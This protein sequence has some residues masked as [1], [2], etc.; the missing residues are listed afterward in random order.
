MTIPDRIAKAATNGAISPWAALLYGRM[1]QLANQEG[2]CIAPLSTLAAEMG[3]T[4]KG[5]RK[6]L[7]EL[8]AIGE[9]Q[10]T[11]TGWV[12][13]VEFS[14]TPGEA[15]QT[16]P[17]PQ[18]QTQPQAQTAPASPPQPPQPPQPETDAAPPPKPPARKKPRP[19]ES[20]IFP[21]ANGKPVDCLKAA[22]AFAAAIT[23]MN[24]PKSRAC[25]SDADTIRKLVAI[26]KVP[27][28]ALIAMLKYLQQRQPDKIQYPVVV[29]SLKSLREKWEALL[30]EQRRT[31]NPNG[32]NTQPQNDIDAQTAR[33]CRNQYM[34]MLTAKWNTITNAPL[35][36]EETETL[37]HA[38]QTQ[39][40]I[41]HGIFAQIIPQQPST[42][43]APS[44]EAPQLAEWSL[45]GGD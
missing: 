39:T 35:T 22:N 7:D 23:Q 32:K 25:R 28:D 21:D 36:Q 37:E 33:W 5:I 17:Q 19:P 45:F 41:R 3:C 6:W 31:A 40:I 9:T 2:A 44:P 43:N 30:N 15:H 16:P 11:R 4:P 10:S 29:A 12:W 27:H 1:Q 20:W 13:K 18:P 24:G 42:R 34:G 8:D 38:Y 14:E 26:D